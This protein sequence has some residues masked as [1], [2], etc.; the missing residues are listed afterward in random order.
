MKINT[1]NADIKSFG[2]RIKYI[3]KTSNIHQKDFAKACNVSEN[4]VSMLVT[5]RRTQC[6]KNTIK[7]ICSLY[8]VNEHWLETGE[9]DPY[10]STAPP[11]CRYT[12]FMLL[13][14]L[15]QLVEDMDESEIGGIIKFAK[16]NR[17]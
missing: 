12:R 5:G 13:H 2:G 4:Y 8:N 1:V 6:S 9:G 17:R 14:E 16:E 3:I 11:S 15:Y 10:C 7:Q